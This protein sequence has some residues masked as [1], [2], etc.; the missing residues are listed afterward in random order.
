[1][2]ERVWPIGQKEAE[3]PSRPVVGIGAVGAARSLRSWA[4]AH[5]LFLAGVTLA[6]LLGVV[7]RA[8][9]ILSA[10]FPLHDGGL[11]YVMAEDIQKAGYRVPPVTSYNDAGIPFAYS[12]LAFYLAALL[13]D[14]TPLTLV[15]V[16][17]LVPLIATSL[18]VIVFVVFARSLLGD[19]TAVVAGA[20]VFAIMPRTFL[21]N[22]MGGGL[23][24]SLGFLFAL[25]ALHQVYLF[26][27]RRSWRYVSTT[28][29]WCVLLVLTHLGSVPFVVFSSMFFLLMYGRHREAVVGS[30]VIAVGTAVLTSP[31][32]GWVLAT[33][34]PEPFLAA[35]ATGGS[36]FSEGESRRKILGVLSRLGVAAWTGGTTAEPLFPLMGTLALF[37]V[38]A[39]LRR[40]R[41]VLPLWWLI[42]ILLDDRQGLTFATVPMAMLA[43]IAVGDIVLP[44]LQRAGSADERTAGGVMARYGARYGLTATVLGFFLLYAIGSAFLNTPAYPS[45]LRF[46]SSLSA[47]ERQAMH[48]V[49]QSTPPS[50]RVVVIPESDWTAWGASKNAEWFPALA[51]RVS[52]TTVQGTE[53]SPR[54]IFANLLAANKLLQPCASADVTCLE[55]WSKKT[56]LTYTHVYIPQPLYMEKFAYLRCCQLLIRSLEQHPG[57]ERIYNGPGAVIFARR[58]P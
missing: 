6:V 55:E 42:I 38:L 27:T 2:S 46:L 14:A 30:I 34:G 33:H 49:S 1:M 35:H 22:I 43:G 56:G 28:I 12:P 57:Y 9:Y 5:R 53:W 15:D 21:W 52:I 13:D 25:L 26:Y 31:W 40:D 20:F 48:W 7:I 54:P 32:W 51:K 8:A 4:T 3:A 29:L 47:E 45:D 18:T 58:A 10:P 37:G 36:I 17:R 19:T 44:L 39:S 11:F 23:T 24:R 41:L 16:F 50:S